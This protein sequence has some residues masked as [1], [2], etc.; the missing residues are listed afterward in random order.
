MFLE[1]HDRTYSPQLVST[2]EKGE[3]TEETPWMGDD[4]GVHSP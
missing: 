2:A 4:G 3:G 1:R